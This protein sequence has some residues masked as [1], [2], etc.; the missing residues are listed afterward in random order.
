[1]VLMKFEWVINVFM[2]QCVFGLDK[3]KVCIVLATEQK[4]WQ[5]LRVNLYLT[6][7][8]ERGIIKPC[9]AGEGEAVVTTQ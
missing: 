5:K 9:L 6:A 1:M 3:S 7:L 2:G 4:R 8:E